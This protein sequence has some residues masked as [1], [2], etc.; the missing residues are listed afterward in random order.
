MPKLKLDSSALSWWV[1][2]INH[3]NSCPVADSWFRYKGRILDWHKAKS[4]FAVIDPERDPGV[5]VVARIYRYFKKFNHATIVMPASWRPSRGTGFELDEVVCCYI[6][7]FF[8]VFLWILPCIK[9]PMRF[10][11]L[12]VTIRAFLRLHSSQRY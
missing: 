5:L 3:G 12:I 4:A 11:S 1:V 7:K 6:L 10:R 8:V 2:I 9:E